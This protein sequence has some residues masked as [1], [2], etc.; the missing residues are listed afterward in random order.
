MAWSRRRPVQLEDAELAAREAEIHDQTRKFWVGVAFTLPLFPPEHGPRLWIAGRLGARGLGQ[1]AD[2]G[3]GNAG[4]VL[5]R[6][7]L[8]RGRL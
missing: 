5:H 4:A 1:L 6:M 7:G 2:A 3:A 8:L